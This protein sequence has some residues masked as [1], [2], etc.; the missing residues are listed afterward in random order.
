[1]KLLLFDID[2]TLLHSGGA[3]K[4]AMV[5]AFEQVYGVADGFHDIRMSGKTDG[6]ILREALD[7][8]NLP[9]VGNQVDHFRKTYFQLL[10]QEIKILTDMQRLMPGVRP[11]LERLRGQPHLVLGLLTGN[12]CRSGFIKLQHFGLDSYFQLGS[13]ADDSERREE[14]LPFVVQRFQAKYAQPLSAGDIFVIGDTPSDIR[15][16]RPHGVRTVAV[17]TGPYTIAELKTENPDFPFEDFSAIEEVVK[18]FL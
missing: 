1:M 8:Q 10:E 17:A 3:G 16:A 12:W 15:C 9:W 6:A 18:I 2:G 4:R 11:L 14:L 13:F 5:V 7:M